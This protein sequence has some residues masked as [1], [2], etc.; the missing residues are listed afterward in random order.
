MFLFL[1][2]QTQNLFMKNLILLFILCCCVSV[3]AQTTWEKKLNI[4]HEGEVAPGEATSIIETKDGG[5]IV[6]GSGV[7]SPSGK[8]IGFIYKLDKNGDSVW[9]KTYEVAYL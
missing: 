5:F 3:Q 1:S 6:T 2:E 7:T 8:F 4:H 9:M